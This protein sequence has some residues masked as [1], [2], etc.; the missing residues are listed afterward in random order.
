MIARTFSLSGPQLG[1]G[2]LEIVREAFL[3]AYS[4]AFSTAESFRPPI[5][6][7]LHVR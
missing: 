6:Y 1:M 4:L 3:C 2:K 7:H 5:V